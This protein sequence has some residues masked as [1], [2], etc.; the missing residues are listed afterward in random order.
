MHILSL[1]VEVNSSSPCHPSMHK[2]LVR[3]LKNPS[4]SECD[5]DIEANQWVL[6]KSKE[7]KCLYI[8]S[9]KTGECF[10]VCSKL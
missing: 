2:T 5:K 4:L 10:K 7:D 8:P 6:F 9:V 3:D 1:I